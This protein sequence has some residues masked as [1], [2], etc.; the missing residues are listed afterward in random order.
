MVGITTVNSP[1]I[2]AP[3]EV[4]PLIIQPLRLRSVALRAA[5]VLETMRPSLRFPVVDLDA[6]AAWVA[7]SADITESDPTLGEVNVVPSKLATITKVSSELVEDSAENAAAAAVVADGVVRSFARAVDLAF[8]TNTT[9]LGPSGL[10]SVAFQTISVGGVHAN[11]DPFAT[12]ISEVERV[13]SVV[14]AF[15]ADFSTCLTLSLLKRF[16]TT[17]QTISNEP[18]LAQSPGDV[19]NPTQRQIL[20]VPLYSAPN[21]CIE[22]GVVWAIANDKVFVVM[23]RDIEIVANPFWYFGSDSTAVR[24]TMRLGFGFPHPA[25]IVKIVATPQGS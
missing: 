10:E 17:T 24:G 15:A 8:F 7:E 1:G 6:T 25:A 20:G 9:S 13:G 19:A 12:A 5:T 3:E 14:T 22:P 4:G 18:L 23:R 21:G 16:G 11:F 2:L